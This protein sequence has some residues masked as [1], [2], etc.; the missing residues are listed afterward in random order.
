MSTL[1]YIEI[2]SNPTEFGTSST[3]DSFPKNSPKKLLNKKREREKNEEKVEI[4]TNANIPQKYEEEFNFLEEHP[5][6]QESISKAIYDVFLKENL[7]ESS[8]EEDIDYNKLYNIQKKVKSLFKVI[9]P[10]IHLFSK[11]NVNLE[12]IFETKYDFSVRTRSKERLP[13]YKQK[14]YIRVIMKRRFINTY[15]IN[16]LNEK[17]AEGGFNDSFAKLPQSFV[18]N[19][20]KGLNSKFM[21]KTVGQIFKGKETYIKEE[22]TNHEHNSV[23]VDQIEQSGNP[24]LNIIL[25]TKICH[26]FDEYLESEEFLVTEINRLKNSKRKEEKDDYYFLKYIYLTKQWKKFYTN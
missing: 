11:A 2:N 8:S 20:E 9:N 16:A 5:E 17:L 21:N 24:E 23:I 13:N 4:K 26:F 6:E 12:E 25:N 19:V 3:Q 18:R 15:L 10:E 7:N 1:S 22:K 14:H